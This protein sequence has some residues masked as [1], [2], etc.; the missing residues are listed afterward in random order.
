MERAQDYDL[1]LR[2][3]ERHAIAA[4]PDLLYAWREHDS[5]VGQRHLDEQKASANRARL[6]A[7]RRFAAT[8]VEGVRSGTLTASG[9]ARCALEPFWEEDGIRPG[10]RGAAALWGTCARRAPRLHASC[11]A[12]SSIRARARLRRILAACAARQTDPATTCAA[13]VAALCA[14]DPTLRFE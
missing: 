7:R 12:L 13:L 3:S 11:R 14:L 1:W 6:A 2:I 10:A 5:S 9:A 4:L 8:L